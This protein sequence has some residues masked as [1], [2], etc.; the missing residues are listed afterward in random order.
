ME[1]WKTSIESNNYEVSDM[2]NVRNRSTQRVLNP[3]ISNKYKRV[4]ITVNN[5][6]RQF[7]VHRMVAGAFLGYPSNLEDMT[8]DHINGDKADNRLCNLEWVTN[9]E[10]IRRAY[11]NNMVPTSKGI[12]K[13]DSRKIRCYADGVFL[14]EFIGLWRVVEWVMSREGTTYASTRNGIARVLN[15]SHYS[16]TYKGYTF[17]QDSDI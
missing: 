4:S 8:V 1:H 17:V 13:K 10:N 14:A 7:R 5:Q 6:K 11:A 2:G 15:P 12:H 3:F 16:V 9:A